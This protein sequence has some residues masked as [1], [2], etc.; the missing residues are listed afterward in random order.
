MPLTTLSE[1]FNMTK[2]PNHTDRYLALDH[3][4]EQIVA[5]YYEL[6]LAG[7]SPEGVIQIVQG[8]KETFELKKEY[9]RE[10]AEGRK[11]SVTARVDMVKREFPSFQMGQNLSYYMPWRGLSN[12]VRVHHDFLVAGHG[13]FMQ[14]MPNE[15]GTF[16]I[17]TPEGMITIAENYEGMILARISATNPTVGRRYDEDKTDNKTSTSISGTTEQ[18]AAQLDDNGNEGTG[19]EAPTLS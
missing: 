2:N 13:E 3:Q 8:M 14:I 1:T 18:Q 9:A 16:D 6:V 7:V 12:T 17:P 11:T 19:S 15:N 4:I 5:G 10:I